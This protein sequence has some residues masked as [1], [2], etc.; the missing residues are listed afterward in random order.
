[1]RKEGVS[2]NSLYLIYD[3]SIDAPREGKTLTIQPVPCY[4]DPTEQP[5]ESQGGLAKSL[6]GHIPAAS[7]LFVDVLPVLSSLVSVY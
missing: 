1:M 2:L 7:S 4:G 6:Q 5:S 3:Q